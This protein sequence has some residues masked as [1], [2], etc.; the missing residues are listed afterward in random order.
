[1]MN[2]FKFLDG[3]RGQLSIINMMSWAILVIVSVVLSPIIRGFLD[4]VISQTNN[5]MEILLL[6][7]ILPVYWLMLIGVLVIYA[8]PRSGQTQY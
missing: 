7:A 3:K 2:F 4:T 5:T 1:M 8:I 6:N